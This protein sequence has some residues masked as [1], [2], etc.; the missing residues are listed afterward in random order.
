MEHTTEIREIDKKRPS[1]NTMKRHEHT[2][3]LRM[4]RS[5]KRL[6]NL[7]YVIKHFQNKFFKIFKILEASLSLFFPI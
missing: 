5:L 6:Y 4:S 2:V 3:K 7:F 1:Q